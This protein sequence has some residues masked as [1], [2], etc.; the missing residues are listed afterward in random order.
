MLDALADNGGPTMTHAY[1]EGSVGID[2]GINTVTT[3]FGIADVCPAVD[4]RGLTRPA[5]GRCDVGAYE[6]QGPFPPADDARRPIRRID[7]ATGQPKQVTEEMMAFTFTGAGQRVRRRVHAGQRAHL[8]V[9]AA[10]ARPDRAARAAG[11]R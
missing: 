11:A 10:R 3:L 1:R 9:P 8:R 5:N 7:P 2:G 4:Q 6:Y